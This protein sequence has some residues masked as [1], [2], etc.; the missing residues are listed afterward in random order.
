M[1]L[2]QYD[3]ESTFPY[4]CERKTPFGQQKE[5]FFKTSRNPLEG[6]KK[7]LKPYNTSRSMNPISDVFYACVCSLGLTCDKQY[8]KPFFP[9]IIFIRYHV[10]KNEVS[11]LELKFLFYFVVFFCLL[12]YKSFWYIVLRQ[13][14]F[15]I[16]KEYVIYLYKTIL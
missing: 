10:A 13:F 9:H 5:V 12:E 14:Y 15:Q 2:L 6:D 7:G 16:F 4:M 11:G 3:L 8:M 1:N